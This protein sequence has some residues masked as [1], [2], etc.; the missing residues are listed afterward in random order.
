[1]ADVRDLVAQYRLVTLTGA[2]GIGKTRLAHRLRATR[3]GRT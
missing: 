2:G 1:M 3:P